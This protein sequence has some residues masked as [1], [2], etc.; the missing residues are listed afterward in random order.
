MAVGAG[1]V[2]ACYEGLP[3]FTGAAVLSAGAP[4]IYVITAA[5]LYS[6]GAH[7]IMTLN[8]FKALEGDRQMGLNSLPVIAGPERAAKIAC[9]VMA[10]P[11]AAMIALLLTWDRPLHALGVAAVLGPATAGHA[12]TAARPQGLCPLVQRHRGSAVRGG[13][14]DHR[15]RHSHI[16][17]RLMTL[18]WLQIFRLGL[19][20]CCL[21]AIVVL[22]TSTL[23][24]L[25]VIELA[26]PAVLPGM[27]VA[28]HYG[29]QLSRPNWGFKSD[30]GGSRTRW[31]IGGMAILG[32]WRFWGRLRV[33]AA[34]DRVFGGSC[35]VHPVLRRD[36]S[37]RR[38]IRHIA[39]GAAGNGHG[40][41][42]PRGGCDN[43]LAD[44]DLWHRHDR[45]HRWRDAAPLFARA[46]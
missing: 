21:G 3:W 20:Q 39:A 37:G 28:L 41:A 43:H 34:G 5:L 35:A 1:R 40:T 17:S 33:V 19:V 10:L 45:R 12:Q 25:M 31:I 14:A 13:D 4:S 24:R 23:N 30:T 27:L 7:G 22:T 26:L 18:S 11:Q 32:G 38:R 36:R 2:R 8:D 16:G 46:C 42:P 44:D 29:I 15:L 9:A 6:V